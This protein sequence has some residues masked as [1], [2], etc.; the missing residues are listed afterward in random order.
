MLVP[1]GPTVPLPLELQQDVVALNEPMPDDAALGGVLDELYKGVRGVPPATAEQ[2]GKVIAATRGLSAFLAEQ[3][4]AMGMSTQGMDV[5]SCWERKR[6]AVNQTNGLKFNT[7]KETFDDIRGLDQIATFM[8]ALFKGENAPRAVLRID[9]IDKQLAGA[10]GGDLSGV[11][12]DAL[13]A[14]LRWTEDEGH[15]GFVA[16]GP[17]GSGKSLVSKAIGG[18]FGVPTLEADLGAAKGGIVGQSEER[19]RTLLKVVSGVAGGGRVLLVATCNRM[20]SLPPE[21]RRRMKFG[22]WYF[23][24]P[25]AEGREAIWRLYF[26]RYKLGAFAPG[27]LPQDEGWTGA[28]IRNCCEL[29]S[30]LSVSVKDAATYIVPIIRSAPEQVR[31]LRDMADGRFLDAAREGVYVAAGGVK[32]AQRQKR[33]F[34]AEEA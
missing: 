2:R 24:L 9:E 12:A 22:M 25:T 13:G 26:E 30:D 23:D 4:F 32:G 7:T 11:S 21:L 19:I 15:T 8:G 31:E 18:T 33:Q 17:G 10:T 20:A 5:D 1:L 6:A 27:L 14:V 16:I 34:A 3:T 29:A 28:E